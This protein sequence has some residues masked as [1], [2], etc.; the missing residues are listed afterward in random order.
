MI[1]C[2]AAGGV[3]YSATGVVVQVVDG[4]GGMGGLLLVGFRVLFEA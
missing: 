2:A 4:A 1:I 3:G